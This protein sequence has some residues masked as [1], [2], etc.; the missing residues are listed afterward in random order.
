MN[1]MT[2]S[3]VPKIKPSLVIKRHQAGVWA[4]LVIL[5]AA[6]LAPGQTSSTSQPPQQPVPKAETVAPASAAEIPTG[7]VDGASSCK[8]RTGDRNCS[9]DRGPFRMV[10]EGQR[11]VSPGGMLSIR[12][13]SYSEAILLNK[14]MSITAYDGTA[15]IRPG[16]LAPF[17]LVADAVDDN[18]LPLNP[19]WGGQTLTTSAANPNGVP[20]NPRQCPQGR[21]V[22]DIGDH[23]PGSFPCTNQFTYLNNG[24]CGPHINWFGVTYTGTMSWGEHSC[25]VTPLFPPIRGALC[26]DDDYDMVLKT[27]KQVGFIADGRGSIECEFDSDETID[28]F[29]SPWWSR[30]HTTVDA[31]GC[32]SSDKP[33]VVGVVCREIA[34]DNTGAQSVIDGSSVIVTGLMGIDTEHGQHVELHPVWALAINVRPSDINVLPSINNELWAFFV[35][36]WGD[37]G[38]CSSDQEFID[39]PNNRYTFRLPWRPGATSVSVTSQSWHPYHTQ[40]PPPS[41]E[42]GSIR[43]VPGVGVFVTFTLDAPRKDGSMWDGELHLKWIP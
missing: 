31:G 41:E 13:G 20:P 33:G 25:P 7:F 6:S 22:G 29:N 9:S 14:I 27:D 11:G 2:S 10:G 17:D 5:L 38:F 36:N 16:P 19:K 39:F 15:T 4:A 35:R 21:D 26:G 37:E 42:N 12:G 24:V 23:D 8:D 18:G 43:K 1:I 32:H 30:F 40:N 3:M 28:H 34:A